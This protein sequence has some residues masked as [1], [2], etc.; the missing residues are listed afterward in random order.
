M[1]P[2]IKTF[3]DA[4]VK[5]WVASGRDAAQAVYDAGLAKHKLKQGEHIMLSDKIRIEVARISKGAGN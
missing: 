1:K 3:L 4:V 2:E 5:A